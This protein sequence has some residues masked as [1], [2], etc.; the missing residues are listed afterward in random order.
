[1]GDET[2]PEANAAAGTGADR[3]LWAPPDGRPSLEKGTQQP[4]QAPAPQPSPQD[5]HPPTMVQPPQSPSV[6]NQATV[7]SMPAEGF[8]PP[9]SASG[10][11]G[12]GQ[13]GTAP[14]APGYGQPATPPGLPTYGTSAYA[15]PNTA[16]GYGTPHPQGAPGPG[17][18]GGYGYP[19]YP[20]GYGWPGMPMAPQNNMGTAAMVLGILSCCLFCIY[21]VV[22]L[23]LGVTAII[24][25]AKGKKRADR[26]EATNRGQAQ[27]GFITGIIGTALGVLTI[28]ALIIGIVFAI[29]HGDSTDTSD[30]DP[31]YNSAPSATAPPLPQA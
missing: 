17:V 9:A 3:D 15:Q 30:S 18:P 25:G 20:Q 27:A 13:P 2:Q 5:Q 7:T 14:G 10:A 28:A 6:H 11:P 29:K 19:G 4:A 21:G 31:Y 8:A 22:S 12:Q 23:V 1:M 24:L 26:G 16:G